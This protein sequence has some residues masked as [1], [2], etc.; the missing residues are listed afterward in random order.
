MEL[1]EIVQNNLV[2]LAFGVI[3]FLVVIIAVR[4][5]RTSRKIGYSDDYRESE[6]EYL[7]QPEVQHPKELPIIEY[8][9]RDVP[10]GNPRDMPAG[11][12]AKK[13]SRN[14]WDPKS[15]KPAPL[16]AIFFISLWLCGWTIG[17]VI[18]GKVF[19][20]GTIE[21]LIW[22]IPAIIGEV[23]AIWMLLRMLASRKRPRR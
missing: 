16:F 19:L 21:I 10:Y 22:L 20:D 13:K 11:A 14:I 12:N 9:D 15:G 8:H 5:S 3:L 4:K 7:Q 2:W 17:I 18:A 23:F 1:D 6:Q